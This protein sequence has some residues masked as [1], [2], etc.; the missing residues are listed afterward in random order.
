MAT[1]TLWVAMGCPFIYIKKKY[2]LAT[3]S[4]ATLNRVDDFHEKE[5]V[6]FHRN[7]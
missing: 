4:D 2:F 5:T 3:E 7:R 1:G 6:P